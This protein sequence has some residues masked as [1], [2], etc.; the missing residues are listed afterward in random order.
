MASAIHLYDW[1]KEIARGK[2]V[3]GGTA[4]VHFQVKAGLHTVGVTFL[5]TQLAPSQDLDEHFLR[6]TIET[7]GLPG[8]KFY[9]HVGK[10]EILGPFKADGR[11][12]V[13]Q[14]TRRFLFVV[15]RIRLKRRPARSRIV[16]TLARH[17]F[18]RPVTPQDD[19]DADD[20]LSAG[21][22]RRK[23]RYRHRAGAAAYL[24]RSR[25]CVPQGS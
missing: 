23:L 13:A 2:A 18:R 8:F 6:S 9:P 16:D 25:V 4:D 15:R 20:F 7:G 11:E 22:Q 12:R 24:G 5:A 1:D 10:M 19:R 17:A 3:H 21:P 14:R